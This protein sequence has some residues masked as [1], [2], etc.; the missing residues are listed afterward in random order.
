MTNSQAFHQF[1][2]HQ[3]LLGISSFLWP[4]QAPTSEQWDWDEILKFYFDSFRTHVNSVMTVPMTHSDGVFNVRRFILRTLK[5]KYWR[6]KV[7]CWRT[8]SWPW[9]TL[10]TEYSSASV[11]MMTASQTQDTGRLSAAWGP[12]WSGGHSRLELDQYFVSNLR[13]QINESLKC[14]RVSD[15][16]FLVSKSDV[17]VWLLSF[18][19]F[20]N[21]DVHFSYF[22]QIHNICN[23]VLSELKT[24]KSDEFMHLSGL[25]VFS[26]L[27]F[28]ASARVSSSS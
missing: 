10:S 18:F 1:T 17:Q 26:K 23:G 19:I 3:N 28:L 25:W 5:Q 24:T 22:M 21:A 9:L 13:N 27:C 14:Y 6:R 8:V 11:T 16:D 12:V 7:R 2:R 4:W 15:T 20:C